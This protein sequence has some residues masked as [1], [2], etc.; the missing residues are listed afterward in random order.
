MS[1]QQLH[2]AVLPPGAPGP[3]DPTRPADPG[4]PSGLDG[5]AGVARTAERGGFDFLL[6]PETAPP[7]PEVLTAL[8][9]LSAATTRLGLAAG[10]DPAVHQPYE[11]A[12]RLA[13]L[14]HLSGGRAAW[15][16]TAGPDG[17]AGG[18]LRHGGPPPEAERPA[19]ATEFLRAARALW[20]SWAEDDV[21]ADQA[22]GVF[23]RPGAGAFTHHGAHFDLSGRFT[24]PRA[25]QGHPVIVRTVASP[26][27]L[28]AAAADADVVVVP[29]TALAEAR[30]LR[31]DLAERLAAH[32][33]APGELR[34]LVSLVPVLG[35]T[36]EQARERAAARVPA[37]HVVGTARQV[38]DA[39]AGYVRGGGSDGFLLTPHPAAGALDAFVDHVVPLLRA[40]GLYRAEYTGTT[41]RDHLG[42]DRARRASRE[43]AA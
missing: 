23:V 14:D 33:R 6:L 37:A 43:T 25:P 34:V 39:L 30:A 20:D 5:L 22:G 38:A 26:R 9:A 13:S 16:L 17:G 41:L 3:A 24:T 27:D 21:P 42:L 36:P 28:A 1:A 10:L 19:H 35:D 32:G 7:G 8:G 29:H 4:G 31:A 2:L 18:R 15:S 11:L 40:E 12:R